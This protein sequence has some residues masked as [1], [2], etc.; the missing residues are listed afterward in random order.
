MEPDY[1][2]EVKKIDWTLGKS[3]EDIP[4]ATPVDELDKEKPLETKEVVENMNKHEKLYMEMVKNQTVNTLE[5]GG[6]ED[7]G[8]QISFIE[9][10]LQKLILLKDEGFTDNIEKYT[11]IQ[12]ALKEKRKNLI[13]E[14]IKCDDEYA[15]NAKNIYEEIKKL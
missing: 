6:I 7:P 13:K 11:G 8:L 4:L 3:K 10:Q 14:V 15:E 5:S 1:D 2:A 12:N 9:D